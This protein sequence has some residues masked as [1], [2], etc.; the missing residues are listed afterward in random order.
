MRRTPRHR[1]DF[2]QIVF[3]CGFSCLKS[4][5]CC[6][7]QIASS[8]IMVSV[9]FSSSCSLARVVG[10]LVA[11]LITQQVHDGRSKRT[12]RQKARSILHEASRCD[13]SRGVGHRT[14]SKSLLKPVDSKHRTFTV[15]ILAQA[16]SSDLSQAQRLQHGPLPPECG[17]TLVESSVCGAVAGGAAIRTVAELTMVSPGGLQLGAPPPQRC[18]TRS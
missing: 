16:S 14:F 8:S 18:M 3:V 9:S 6:V 10:S 13:G 5:S 12:S 7:C 1:G 15:A 17:A 4:L 11:E 2:V